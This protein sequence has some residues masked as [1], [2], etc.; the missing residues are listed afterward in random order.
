MPYTNTVFQCTSDRVKESLRYNNFDAGRIAIHRGPEH[1]MVTTY[2]DGSAIVWEP[3][4]MC[5]K[6]TH[7]LVGGG[8]VLGNTATRAE[9]GLTSQKLDKKKTGDSTRRAYALLV[10]ILPEYTG[11]ELKEG[12]WVVRKKAGGQI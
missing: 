2:E 7:I 5:W 10:K 1:A 4:E 8:E 6:H 9:G 3:G 11:A 12:K